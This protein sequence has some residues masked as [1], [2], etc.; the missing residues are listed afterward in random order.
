[1]G[2]K[3]KKNKFYSSKKSNKLKN[4]KINNKRKLEDTENKKLIVGTFE[5]SRNFGFVV[6]DGKKVDTDVFISKKY[7]MG[8]RNGQKVLVEITKE[9]TKERKTEGRIIEIIGNQDDIG[10][11]MLCIIKEFGLPDKFPKEVKNEVKFINNKVDKK[12]IPNRKDFRDLD[13]FTI[14]GEDAKDLDDAISISENE[15]GT[16]T[17][18]VHIADV[19]YYVKDGSSLDKEAVYRGTSVYMLDRV[20]PMLPFELSNGIC[21]LNA[22]EDRFTIS[23]IMDIDDTGK[24]IKSK[25]FKGI[26][27]VKERM[28]YTNV[29]KILDGQDK[30]VLNRYKNY[31][32][33]F[34]NMEKLA[35][36]LKARRIADG[37]LNLD[38]LETQIILDEN[39]K[40]I[41]VKPYETKFANEIIEQFMLTANEEIAETFNSYNAPFI[42]RVHEVPDLEKI[43]ELNKTLYDF[44]YSIKVK[45]DKVSP[46]EFARLLK[47]IKGKDEEKLISKLVLRTLR[48]AK[49]E[50][51]NKG[52]FGIASKYYC[53]FTSPIRRY[54]DLFIHRIISSYLDRNS[55][56]ILTPKRVAKFRKQAEEYAKISSER[57]RNAQNAEREAESMKMAEY[58]E[59]KIGEQY[60]AIVS[61]I[62]SFG[63][64]VELEN[65]IEGLIR[66]ENM[67]DDYYIYDEEHNKLIGEKKKKEYKIG[68]KVKVEVVEASKMLRRVSFKMVL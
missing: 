56:E 15:D 13:I 58:M 55:K 10:I 49:Y 48:L 5:K 57:E 12:D 1:M 45:D 44:G 64:F 43:E 25:I 21:S 41:D 52:H 59:D 37:Y 30:K 22:G 27:N 8:A 14:D 4:K 54:P 7:T 60:D 24:V 2:R 9:P 18:G 32:Q 42:Y 65:T 40:P 46:K 3:N 29:Q 20:I 28:S 6:P 62:T 16:F 61:S 66:F 19:S 47:D 68:D 50:A 36:I 11:D 23:I 63:M 67:D 38:L 53:H 31:I 51:E 17:L 39:G 34:K 35:K 33:D 26:I